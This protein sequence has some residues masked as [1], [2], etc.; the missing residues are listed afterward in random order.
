[1][2]AAGHTYNKLIIFGFKNSSNVSNL[3][4]FDSL[5]QEDF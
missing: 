4:M 2:P 1:M 3:S 5:A